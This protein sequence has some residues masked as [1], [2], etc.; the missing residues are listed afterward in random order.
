MEYRVHRG[1]VLWL[2]RMS[3]SRFFKDMVSCT[4]ASQTSR[5]FSSLPQEL[6]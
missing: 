6:C 5:L 3:A 2:D 4:Y 1:G